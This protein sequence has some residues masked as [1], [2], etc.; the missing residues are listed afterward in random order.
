MGWIGHGKRSSKD[1]TL[2]TGWIKKVD[3]RKEGKRCWRDMIYDH[4]RTAK[5]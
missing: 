1:T 3:Q 4:Q 2:A 5:D